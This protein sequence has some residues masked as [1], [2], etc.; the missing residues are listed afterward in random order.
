VLVEV[1]TE[2][3]EYYLLDR[4]D[5]TEYYVGWTIRRISDD[6]FQSAG[7]LFKTKEEQHAAAT[8]WPVNQKDKCENF[9]IWVY[10]HY[11]TIRCEQVRQ[12]KAA[13]WG[14]LAVAVTLYLVQKLL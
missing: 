9:N 11:E 6:S 3:E 4:G 8:R 10:W 7:V 14:V 2:V 12:A 5:M 1:R 13:L